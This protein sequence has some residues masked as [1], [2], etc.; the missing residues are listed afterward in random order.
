MTKTPLLI[1]P[2]ISEQQ[3]IE[4]TQRT[5][6]AIVQSAPVSG[7]YLQLSATGLALC[8]NDQS[9]HRLRIDFTEGRQGF[10]LRQRGQ[11]RE[12]I[13]RACG[14]GKAP[15]IQIVDATA[16]LGHDAFV[17]AS[18]GAYVTMLERSAVVAA[19]LDDGLQRARCDGAHEIIERLT[20]IHTEA[21]EWLTRQDWPAADVIYLDPMYRP[22]RR[23]AAAAKP[24]AILEKLLEQQQQNDAALLNTALQAAGK[25]VVVKRQRLA[26]T[27][28]QAQ[29]NF[30]LNGRSTRFDVYIPG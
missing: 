4:I 2:E 7:Q 16:G 21:I 29:P 5:G 15:G 9:K 24:L 14:M 27:L 11:A 23:K 28:G 20:L 3:G 22:A 13:V 25:R 6:A 1:S 17:L 30:S 8:D 26:P 12:G 18:H 10:R 19:L